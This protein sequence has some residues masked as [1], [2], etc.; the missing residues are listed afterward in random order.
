[1]STCQPILNV[2]LNYSV[3]LHPFHR[4]GRFFNQVHVCRPDG[5]PCTNRPF[6][7]QREGSA[8]QFLPRCTCAGNRRGSAEKRTD[9]LLQ[10]QAEKGN[11]G[12][13]SRICQ[14]AVPPLII[15]FLCLADLT[16][17]LRKKQQQL[18]FSS[19]QLL[20]LLFFCFSIFPCRFHPRCK[21]HIEIGLCVIRKQIKQLQNPHADLLPQRVILSPARL[22]LFFFQIVMPFVRK[23]FI[24]SELRRVE[25]AADFDFCLI[26]LRTFADLKKIGKRSVLIQPSKRKHPAEARPRIVNAAPALII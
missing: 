21:L 4:S 3:T 1:M 7:P 18:V 11:T 19:N 26:L 9:R 20:P 22:V 6:F 16:L 10:P 17:I 12:S 5:M 13:F 24:L 2:I 14:G 8:D 25:P 15:C 23:R